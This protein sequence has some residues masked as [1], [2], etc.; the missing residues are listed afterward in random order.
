MRVMRIDLRLG[1]CE[2][3]L[4]DIPDDSIDAIVCDP[5]YGL[6]R[7]PPVV[8]VM[9][10]WV[11]GEDYH[12]KGGGFMAREWDA[13]VPGPRVWR[14]IHRVLKPGGHCVAFA[15]TRTV[16]WMGMAMRFGG[17]TE[18]RDC[19]VWCYWSGFP[20]SVDVAKELDKARDD[21][22]AIR[23]WCR[24][25]RET[26]DAHPTHSILSLA[27]HFGVHRRMVKHWSARDTDSQP[28]LPTLD[29]AA[30]LLELLGARPP[31]D[32]LE[33]L[34][35]YNDRKGTW[36]NERPDR[37]SV[38]EPDRLVY[39][40]GHRLITPGEPVTD[41]ARAWQGF[42]TAV[43]PA[44]EPWILARKAMDGTIAQNVRKWGTGVLNI[45]ACRFA[46][47]D[48]MWPGPQDNDDT[49]RPGNQF[50]G[51]LYGDGREGFGGGHPGGRFPANLVH[52]PKASRAERET[53]CDGLPVVAGFDAVDRA[54]GSAGLSS[55]RT[56]AGRTAGEVR[57]FH[58]TVKPVA[59]MR[60]L[61]RL[62]TPPGG[63]VLDPFMGSGTTGIAAVGQGFGFVGCELDAGHIR[64][65]R[66]RIAHAAPGHRVDAP[67]EA[68]EGVAEPIQRGLFG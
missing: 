58:N 44:W 48:P 55:P 43:K 10:A 3:V 49:V 15:G 31:A 4:A 59:L 5:P 61:V 25:L 29:Q 27:E 66:A 64:I 46:P 16:D 33:V 65:A 56:G 45:D 54:E 39:G 51:L 20:K 42:G 41:E 21:T 18:I 22:D 50:R 12:A 68:L 19:G 38:A 36:E 9:S 40:P 6:G 23:P 60:W 2:E 37:E 7:P 17:F 26:I 28:C 13:F 57:N 47:G 63:T 14:E 53:G 67:E 1:R 35:V 8:E 11:R 52:S 30:E 32:V 62:V 34:E 24:W